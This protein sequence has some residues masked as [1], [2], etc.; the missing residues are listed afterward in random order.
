[1]FANYHTHTFR[2]GHAVGSDRAYV[3]AAIANGMKVLGFSEHCPWVFPD[4]YVSGM[5]LPLDA[6]DDYFGAL[7]RLKEE[8]ADRITIYIGFESEYFPELIEAQQRFLEKYPVDYMIL[9]QHF[10]MPEPNGIYTGRSTE[11]KDDLKRYVDIVIEGME[12]GLYRY[13]AHPDLLNFKGDDRVYEYEYERLCRYLK[14]KQ[15]PIELNQLGLTSKRH[16]PSERFLKIA[17]KVGN[18][19]IVGCDAHEP[20]MLKDSQGQKGC[21]ALAEKFHLPLVTVLDGLD[22][23]LARA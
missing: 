10:C 4:G 13:V 3:E 6:A 11:N 9:G 7:L 23:K 12:T 21:K 20:E 1:M 16:Y 19:A 2:C 17:E 8:Y 15:I 18:S 22:T 5:R 14:E